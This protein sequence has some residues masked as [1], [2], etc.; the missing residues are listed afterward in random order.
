MTWFILM[1]LQKPYGT[2]KFSACSIEPIGETSH[3]PYWLH[4]TSYKRLGH[5]WVISAWI[6][7]LEQHMT[8]RLSDK[9]TWSPTLPRHLLVCYNYM[10]QELAF[11]TMATGIVIE[12]PHSLPIKRPPVLVMQWWDAH[13]RGLSRNHPFPYTVTPALKVSKWIL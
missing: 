4:Y 8:I 2:W 3:L 10:E 7:S 9:D 1:L 12:W 13:R 11:F 5:L 6:Q